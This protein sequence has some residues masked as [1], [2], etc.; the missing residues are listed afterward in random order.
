MSHD[1]IHTILIDPSTK[2]LEQSISVTPAKTYRQY[3]QTTMAMI[4]STM[5]DRL[6]GEHIIAANSRGAL[7]TVP[8]K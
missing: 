5:I 1:A 6:W 2:Y 3:R 7:E 8:L 4:V